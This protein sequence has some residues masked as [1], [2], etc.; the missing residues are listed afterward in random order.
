[1]KQKSNKQLE[2]EEKILKYLNAWKEYSFREYEYLRD[3][4][5]PNQPCVL[6]VTNSKIRYKQA[7]ENKIEELNSL[8]YKEVN[9]GN[10]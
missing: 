8:I 7:L 3:G 10:L 6:S 2:L 1:M 9:N 5:S 4:F